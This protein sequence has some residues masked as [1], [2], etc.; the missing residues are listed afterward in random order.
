MRLREFY[1]SK[2]HLSYDP[3][4]KQP[5]QGAI[6]SDMDG[7]KFELYE[8]AGAVWAIRWGAKNS[9]CPADASDVTAY[10]VKFSAPGTTFFRGGAQA[11]AMAHELATKYPLPKQDEENV[12]EAEEPHKSTSGGAR[13]KAAS[14]TA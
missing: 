9:L 6:Q 7:I 4:S 2:Q 5:F 1:P 13:R 14:A 10:I 3:M 11:E 8:H 12:G